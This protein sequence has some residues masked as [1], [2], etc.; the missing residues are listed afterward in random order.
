MSAAVDPCVLVYDV[1]GSHISAAVCFKQG[2]RL[3]TVV[4]ANLPEEQTS[5]AFVEVL[6]SLGNEGE[7][8][9]ARASRVRNWRCRGRSTTRKASVG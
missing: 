4:R 3:G 5:E 8:R 6:H 7:R 1:G 2:F 9:C